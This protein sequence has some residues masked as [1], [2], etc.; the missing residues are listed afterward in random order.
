M[1]V[2]A[3][4]DRICYDTFRL[5]T[6]TSAED[7][8][9]RRKRGRPE[10]D[11]TITAMDEIYT[12]IQRHDEECQ[13]TIDDFKS[14]VS[15]ECPDD[16]T[17]VKKIR[18]KYGDQVIISSSAGKPKIFCF[19]S[20]FYNVLHDTWYTAKCA[21]KREE[22]LRIVKTAASIILEEIRTTPYDTS[23]YPPPDRFVESAKDDVPEYLYTLL[24]ELI[25]KNKADTVSASRKCVAIA[26]AIMTACRPRSFTSSV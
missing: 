8:R 23:Q 12:F 2:Q 10:C 1:A 16:R 26:H 15:G 5:P 4:Y 9:T 17:I 25:V 24:E 21:D 18:E 3:K 6:T 14:A 7:S 22:K 13:L 11:H 20:A 19:G